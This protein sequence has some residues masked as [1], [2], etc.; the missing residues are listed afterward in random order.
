MVHVSDVNEPPEFLRSHYSV[1]ISEGAGPGDVLY[2]D[3]EALDQD[4]AN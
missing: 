3:V 1:A 4:E 2:S